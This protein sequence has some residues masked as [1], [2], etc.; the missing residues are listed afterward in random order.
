MRKFKE[1]ENDSGVSKRQEKEEDVEDNFKVLQE[2]HGKNKQFTTPMLRLWAGTISAGLHTI[3][4]AAI[5][6]GFIQIII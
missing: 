4:E 2:K 5:S 1:K 6:I 3:S